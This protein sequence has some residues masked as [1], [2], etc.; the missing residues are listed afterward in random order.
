MHNTVMANRLLPGNGP[1][2]PER[3]NHEQNR[4]IQALLG[5][6]DARRSGSR[7]AARS[8]G[9]RLRPSQSLSARGVSAR[10]DCHQLPPRVRLHRHQRL[11]LPDV[12]RRLQLGR[13]P[14]QAPAPRI[15]PRMPRLAARLL[16]SQIS[17]WRRFIIDAL[18]QRHWL[19]DGSLVFAFLPQA[20]AREEAGTNPAT[21]S[22][23]AVVH[24]VRD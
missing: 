24:R 1:G 8:P 12:P 11:L 13:S 14:G 9:K 17:E 23:R 2:P 19:S 16:R 7:G 15:T 6:A 4:Q 18:P 21:P 3:P 20:T 10:V 22:R 5:Q